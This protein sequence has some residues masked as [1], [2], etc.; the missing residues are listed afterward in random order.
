VHA[1]IDEGSGLRLILEPEDWADS[2]EVGVVLALEG[3]APIAREL[4]LLDLLVRLGVRSVQLTWNDRN[5]AAAGIDVEGDR[6]LSEFGRACVDRLNR[7][8]V[9]IDV[10]HLA[11]EGIDE[12]LERSTVPVMCS[13]AN[14]RALCDHPRNLYDEQ[15]RA[16]AERGG[17]VGVVSYG[18]FIAKEGATLGHLIDHVEHVMDI[19]GPE[20]VGIGTDFMYYVADLIEAVLVEKPMY[21]TA[22]QM[23]APE[24]FETLAGFPALWAGMRERGHSEDVIAGMAGGNF[25]R[26]FAEVRA[27]AAR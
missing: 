10:A 12:I 15:I 13:H 25:Q 9:V 6:G 27:G 7:L 5:D 16:I 1:E 20:H 22:Q 11:A 24:G 21:Q 3:I 19:A 2:P 4:W 23:V 8:G 17:L 18:D 14:A 26:L